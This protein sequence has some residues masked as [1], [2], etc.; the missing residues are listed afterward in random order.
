MT[1][2]IPRLRLSVP[3]LMAGAALTAALAGCGGSSSS[4]AGAATT[5]TSP[6]TSSAP[7]A[8]AGTRT[9][10]GASGSVAAI[11]GSS[12]EVQNPQS[13]QV[14]V[15][16]TKSTAFSETV[17]LPATSVAAGDCVS[18][19]G[20]LSKGMIT[21]KSVTV[22]RPIKGKCG[23]SRVGGG[24][25]GGGGFG[26]GGRFGNRP[27]AAGSSGSAPARGSAGGSGPRRGF[28]G[29]ANFALAT[30]KVT[31]VSKDTL[32]ISGF[33]TSSLTR[34]PASAPK[35]KPSIKTTTVKIAVTSSTAYSETKKA[36]S[37]DLAVGDCVTAV[38]KSDSTGAI[39]AS[40]VR[41]TS[42]GGKSCTT[43]FAGG[44]GRG[45]GSTGA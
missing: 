14:T 23:A 3:V 43:G 12:M 25:F 27:G 6:P 11:T 30:G 41:V 8:G 5:T 38:G 4:T 19:T 40:T 44:F 20:T 1:R 39:K 16:W 33:S 34:R 24:G 7:A 42:T 28:P 21:A 22:S 45:G 17:K 32:V 29:A 26:G 13:G 15:S 2:S 37:A 10:P 18:A 35:T 9:F 31:S 36:K